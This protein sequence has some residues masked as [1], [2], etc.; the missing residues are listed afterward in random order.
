MRIIST[1]LLFLMAL[2]VGATAFAND[3]AI[4]NGRVLV[5]PESDGRFSVDRNKMGKS[6]LLA[7]IGDLKD[8]K[9]V[10]GVVLKRA[11]QASA[12]QKHLLIE[13]AQYWELDAV[14]E[15][16]NDVTPLTE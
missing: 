1:G 7:V 2:L 3:R 9:H 5:S 13:I 6:Q 15:N 11:D 8:S 14:A 16:G 12:E 4:A 10:T